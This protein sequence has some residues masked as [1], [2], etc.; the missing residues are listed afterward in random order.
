MRAAGSDLVE[1]PEGWAVGNEY[2]QVVG[3]FDPG[4]AWPPSHGDT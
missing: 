1:N 2:V 4:T 3:H